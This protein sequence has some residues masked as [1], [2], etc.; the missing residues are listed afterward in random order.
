MFC[1]IVQH[2]GHMVLGQA[3]LSV[4]LSRL[5]ADQSSI[6]TTDTCPHYRSIYHCVFLRG[7]KVDKKVL[8]VQGP[9]LIDPAVTEFVPL[10]SLEVCP[11]GTYCHS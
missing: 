10:I 8:I 3:F 1:F 9:S 4:V 7:N 2:L 6:K 11:Y 5:I